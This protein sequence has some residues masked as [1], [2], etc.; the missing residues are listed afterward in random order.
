MF[1]FLKE[2]IGDAYTDEVEKKA[3]AEIGKT[4]VPKSKY[5][6]VNAEKKTLEGQIK[7][8]DG[9][10]EELKKVNP[11]DLKAQIE[12]LQAENK[13]AAEKY[14]ADLTQVKMDAAIENELIK[15]KAVNT[16]AVR[17]LLDA[18]KIVFDGDK[19]KGLDEQLAALKESDKWAFAEETVTTGRQQGKG[20]G[21]EPTVE[22]AILSQ[23]YPKT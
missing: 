19:L 23:I 3:A 7:E 6:E 8:R 18:G 10:L 21:A 11:D 22:D 1:E 15:A 16:K 5:D 13:T 4:M 14:A 20:S 2:L 12:T 9:Q 17:A